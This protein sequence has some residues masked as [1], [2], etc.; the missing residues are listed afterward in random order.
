MR[1]CLFVL[2]SADLLYLGQRLRSDVLEHLEETLRNQ[3]LRPI[4]EQRYGARGLVVAKE[5]GCRIYSANRI[6][7]RLYYARQH[8]SPSLA[9]HDRV[10]RRRASDPAG[11]QMI[12]EQFFDPRER[13]QQ[14]VEVGCGLEATAALHGCDDITQRRARGT[15]ARR[16]RSEVLDRGCRECRL[17][18]RAVRGIAILLGGLELPARELEIAQVVGPEL[19]VRDD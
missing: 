9:G 5:C 14:R 7:T 18:L 11:L 16:Q 19:S 8:R 3:P 15:D 17:D 1:Q 4:Q 10:S 13:L 6:L 2:H 12:G